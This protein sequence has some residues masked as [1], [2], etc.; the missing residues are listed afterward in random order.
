MLKRILILL[1]IISLVLPLFTVCLAADQAYTVNFYENSEITNIG[2]MSVTTVNARTG[3]TTVDER[4][5]FW[6][7]LSSKDYGK[8]VFGPGETT[9]YIDGKTVSTIYYFIDASQNPTSIAGVSTQSKTILLDPNDSDFQNVETS[10]S[11]KQ[12]DMTL[13]EGFSFPVSAKNLLIWI[14]FGDRISGYSYCG[15]IV[16]YVEENETPIIT[17]DEPYTVNFYENSEITN[18]GTM[19]VTTVNARTGATTVDERDLFWV[20]LSSKD[21]GKVVFG[22]GETTKYIDGKTVS[23]IYYFI[24]ASQNPTSIAGVST[25][26]KTILLDLNDSDFQNV[27]TSFSVKQNDMTLNEGFSFPVSAKNLLIW[28]VFGDRI[29]GFEYC[30]LVVSYTR[31]GGLTQPVNKSIL[32]A[33]IT[34]VWSGADYTDN[35]YK[36]N[37]RYNGKPGDTITNKRSGFWMEFTAEDGPLAAAQAVFD[38]P[39]A[40]QAKVD[41]AAAALS[42]AIAK[43]IP[44][45]Q[46]NATKLYETITQYENTYSETGQGILLSDFTEPTANAYRAALQ[47][48]KDYLATLF[49]S[50][51]SA[52]DGVNIADHQY[53]ADGCADALTAAVS[54]LLNKEDVGMFEVY[55]GTISSLNCLFDETENGGRYTE[56]SWNAFTTARNS[57]ND[58]LAAHPITA[59]STGTELQQYRTLAEAYWSA[60]Y[61]LTPS[62]NAAVSLRFADNGGAKYPDSAVDSGLALY[63]DSVTLTAETGYTLEALL[64]KAD[65]ASK[66]TSLGGYTYLVYVNGV[67]L[68]PPFYYESDYQYSVYLSENPRSADWNDV[69]LRDGDEVV[70]VRAL[71][72]TYT[73]YISTEYVGF[74][75]VKDNFGTL[76]YRD[77][78]ELTIKAGEEFSVN[79][80][81]AEGYLLNYDGRYSQATNTELIVYGP[82]QADG[83]YPMTCSGSVTNGG[84]TATLALLEA[85]EYYVTAV[86]TRD[87]KEAPDYFYPN[88]MAGCT[89]IKVTVTALTGAELDNARSEYLAE[90]NAAYDT[91]TEG[92]YTSTNWSVLTGCYTAARETINAADSLQDMRNA[93]DA[94]K[95]DMAAVEA[96]D[97]ESVLTLFDHYLKYLPSIEQISEGH[98]TQADRERMGWINELYASMSDFQKDML[99]A[100]QRSQYEALLAAYGEDGSELPESATFTV[101]VNTDEN[102]VVYD[103]ASSQLWDYYYDK[104]GTLHQINGIG[105]DRNTLDAGNNPSIIVGTGSHKSDIILLEVNISRDYYSHFDGIEVSGAEVDNIETEEYQYYYRYHYYILNPYHD[106]SIR[107]KSISDSLQKTKNEA[108]TALETEF[109]RYKKSDYTAENWEILA[110]AYSDGVT[111]INAATDTDGV[112]AAKK[113][114]VDAM[115]EVPKKTGSSLGT[116]TVIV[117]NTTFPEGDFSGTIIGA[118]SVTLEESSSMMKAALTALHNAGYSWNGTGGTGYEIT[119]L[120]YIYKDTNENGKYDQGEPKLGEFSGTPESGWMGTLNDWF[121]NE[122]LASFTVANGKLEDGDV[123]RILFTNAGLG[124]DLGATWA[125]NDT[126]LLSLTVTGGS[127]APAFDPGVM[128]YILSPTGSSVSFQA[129]AANKNFQVRIFLNEQNKTADADYYRSGESIPVKSG[130]VIWIG[131]GEKAWPTMNENTIIGTWYKLTVVNSGDSGAVVNLINDIG[132]VTFANYKSRE[133]AITQARAAYEALSSAAQAQ[134][135]NYQTL[136]NAETALASYQQVGAVKDEIAALPKNIT[137]ASRDTVEAAYEHYSALSQT[138]KDL[139]SN[140]ETNKL[141]KAVNTLTLMDKLKTVPATK[142]FDSAVAGSNDALIAALKDWLGPDGLNIAESSRIMVEVGSFTEATVSGNGSYNATVSFTLGDGAAAATQTKDI[143]GVITRSG[144]TGVTGIKVS[145]VPA[146]GSGTAWTA[147]LPYGTD[148]KTLTGE[149]FEITLKDEKAQVSEGPAAP[150]NGETW[151]FIV[152]A[153][154]GTTAAYTVTLSVSEVA[155]KVLDSWIYSL[156]DDAEPVKLDPAAVTGLLEAVSVDALELPAGT[157]EAFLWL[158][159]REKAG[160]NVYEIMPV[161]AADEEGSRAVPAAALI[162]KIGL[163]LPVPGTEYAKVL[164]GTEY[165]DAQGDA[166][167]I[168]F[169]V[170]E[171]GDYTL[172]P[173]ARIATVTFHLC[174]GSSGEVTDGETVVYYR[175]DLNKELPIAVK[176]GSGFAGW[177]AK[178]DGSGQVYSAVSAALP[179]DLYAVWQTELPEELKI[180]ELTT[181]ATVTSAVEEDGTAVITVKA[182]VPCVVIM[183]TGDSYE[184]LEGVEN[185]DGSYSFR[186]ENYDES[187]EFFVAAKGDYD[188]DGVFRTVDLAKANM[189][190]VAN[191]A[192]DPLTILIMGVD[193]GKLRTVDLAMLNLSIINKD[194][195]W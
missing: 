27:E 105:F 32:E 114:A 73:V 181:A 176:D 45:T 149:A 59:N 186:Q 56:S 107:I 26:S 182:D 31:E 52:V 118:T 123:I 144:E 187:M 61:N 14:V 29:S 138:Q 49:D 152:T 121:V 88:L 169:D 115:A 179:A 173:D 95:E 35:Y 5:L 23:T 108:L 81:G 122:S 192:I 172:I 15:L 37:D 166:N 150:N 82:K 10:F 161:F 180:T 168:R 120:S 19:S 165:L 136:V 74:G 4:D 109:N 65:I 184:L 8:V 195:D 42:T 20:S 193:S 30:G 9:K 62:G 99:T 53:V 86:D 159:V 41:A 64:T 13:N 69:C 116:V 147:T 177:H 70:I 125:N 97:H 131:V 28:I 1:L 90:L 68:R 127:F 44:T 50:T 92:Y 75:Y 16:S 130:D 178:E 140:M 113:T 84:G 12:N 40:T 76:R 106:F 188:G 160:D 36:N 98:F 137:E 83:S 162:G 80:S 51:G 143:S 96:I 112:A 128:E 2:T 17:S 63:S 21:Y 153:L 72:P 55:R 139:L 78:A 67:L 156:S 189:D 58:Y 87:L 48:A 133:S 174:G 167:G 11:V 91:Y 39:N 191:K 60:C 33:E 185:A 148:L 93:V 151:S 6:V 43:L 194:L 119:Y 77:S 171:A 101:T 175:K 57:A 158:E 157:E 132:S 145:G 163:T 183:K 79:V 102:A 155:V 146:T 24:D 46:L 71:M 126:S 100:T 7:S 94:A 18:I 54:G 104:A 25:Q 111:A 38:D 110:A 164:F 135:T 141:L 47:T 190:L 34:K 85:G 129:T 124:T 22:P 170:A 66:L 142:D 89:P 154:D 3:A 103:A 134:V 117:E